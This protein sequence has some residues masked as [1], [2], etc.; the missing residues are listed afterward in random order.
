MWSTVSGEKVLLT[1]FLAHACRNVSHYVDFATMFQCVSNFGIHH[2]FF[3]SG[4]PFISLSDP[5][6]DPQIGIRV[7]QGD[8]LVNRPARIAALNVQWPA[9]FRVAKD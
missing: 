9:S 3:H 2:C 8:D 4:Y 5:K 6:I 1:R 7:V